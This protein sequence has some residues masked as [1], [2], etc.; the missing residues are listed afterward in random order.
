MAVASC[1]RAFTLI[2]LLVVIAIVAILAGM[3]LPAI[4]MVKETAKTMR[5]MSSIRQM[6]LVIETYSQDNETNLPYLQFTYGA[7][8]NHYE[9]W[10]SQ[11][12]PY[13]DMGPE[14]PNRWDSALILAK[15]NGKTIA[16]GCPE[17]KGTSP[18]RPGYG[19]SYFPGSPGLLATGDT[20]NGPWFREISKNACSDQ[21]KRILLGETQELYLTIANP[22]W[23]TTPS[24][25]QFNPAYGE[26][27]RHMKS[28]AN[29]CFFDLHAQTIPASKSPWLGI[30]K[31]ADPAWNP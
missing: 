5:C 4:S 23:F 25:T 12:F 18:Y 2:E 27:L 11:V 20:G 8:Y 6:G 9:V 22:G 7:P 24:A 17:F 15:G 19:M 28:K 30:Q 21:S 16:R 14:D 29:Y 3:L 13:L 26:P 10:L 1:S 31:P